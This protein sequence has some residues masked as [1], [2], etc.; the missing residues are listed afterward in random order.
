MKTNREPEPETE[1]IE[2]QL[3]DLLHAL[4]ATRRRLVIH[5][6]DND[7]HEVVPTR[8]LAQQIAA[9]EN[10]IE[11]DY[12]SGEPYKN[13]YNALSQTHL[14]TLTSAGIIVY[15]SKRQTVQKG[16]VFDLGYLLLNLTQ[17]AIETFFRQYATN[18]E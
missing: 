18:V 10:G 3:S 2:E 15:D 4:R 9:K 14:P 8:L 12:V 16:S 5:S 7:S 1:D 11:V 6:L 17:P 13:V